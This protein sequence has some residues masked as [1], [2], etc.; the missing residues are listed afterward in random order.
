LILEAWER[1][2]EELGG[3]AQLNRTGGWDRKG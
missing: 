2:E 1:L 3:Q